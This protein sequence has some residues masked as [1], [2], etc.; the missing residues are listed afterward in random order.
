MRSL[1]LPVL[2]LC[3]QLSD[4]RG[5]ILL[6]HPVST[7]AIPACEKSPVWRLCRRSYPCTTRRL[8]CAGFLGIVA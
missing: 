8:S 3:E 4:D 6:A 1:C 2:L 5:N 7:S